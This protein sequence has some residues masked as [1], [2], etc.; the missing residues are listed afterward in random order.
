MQKCLSIFILLTFVLKLSIAKTLVA[1]AVE[2]IV[3]NFY[4]NKSES[5]DFFIH[6][7]ETRKMNDIVNEVAK[8][9]QVPLRVYKIDHFEGQ[10]KINRSA[11]LMFDSLASYHSFHSQS[12][13]G[14]VHPSDFFFV[15]YIESFHDEVNKIVT[16]SDSNHPM[17]ATLFRYAVFLLHQNDSLSL[18][19]FVI[20]QQPDCRKWQPVQVNWFSKLSKKWI[21][22]E[23][24]LEKFTNFNGCELVIRVLYPQTMIINATLDKNGV[25]KDVWG[26]AKVFNDHISQKLNY[27]F[28][29]NLFKKNIY[30][31]KSMKIDFE[32]LG[33]SMR[34]LK[35]RNFRHVVTERYTTV[36]DVIIIARPFPYTQFEKIFLPFDSDGKLNLC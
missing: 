11:I 8:K 17:R 16:T 4:E 21:K 31:N 28:V 6:G 33:A 23:F 7:T 1:T 19:T 35:V 25:L 14:N 13:L 10:I 29:F 30:Y 27:S 26:C 24:F 36:D 5:F 34:R 15:A 12:V 3:R 18:T 20:F 22:N 32:I 9:T 2:Q